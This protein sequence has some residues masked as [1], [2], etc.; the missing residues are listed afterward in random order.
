MGKGVAPRFQL[1]VVPHSL[2]LLNLLFYLPFAS[3]SISP[4][5]P[6]S[7]PTELFQKGR[8]SLRTSKPLGVPFLL[9]GTFSLLFFLS[10]L[11]YSCSSFR[12]LLKYDFHMQSMSFHRAPVFLLVQSLA[13]CTSIVFYL[14][15]PFVINLFYKYEQVF[16][17]SN[18][19]KG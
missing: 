9:S 13:L 4:L 2:P 19:Q 8:L 11:A 10:C 16:F 15:L 7:N 17:H 5:T 12:S 14:S 3:F 6:N 18:E 1:Q